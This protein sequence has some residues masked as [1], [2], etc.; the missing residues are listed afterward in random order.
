MLTP[1]GCTVRRQRFWAQLPDPRPDAVL[2]VDPL[3]LNY[4]ANFWASPF[5]FRSQGAAA[6][7]LLTADGKARL[8][9]DN[10]LEPYAALAHVDERIVPTWYDGRHAPGGRG[11]LLWE[12]VGELVRSCVP[13]VGSLG[14]DSPL[15][16]VAGTWVRT[17][18]DVE[19]VL[20]RLRQCKEPDELELLRRSAR[21][22]GVGLRRAREEARPGL[23]ELDLFHVVQAAVQH[24]LG[25]PV[26][27]YGDFVS[28]PR[29]AAG[30]G[31]PSSRRLEVGDLVLFDF[32]PVIHGYRA[33][34]CT[35]FV[36]GGDFD[37][38]QARCAQACRAALA[39]GAALLRPGQS[40]QS[41]Y[42]AVRQVFQEH[43]L[44]DRFPHHAGHGIGLSHPE[45]PFLTELSN[46]T[47]APG[48]VVTLEPGVYFPD[49]WGMRFE[50]D[51]LI[52][53]RG[54]VPLTDHEPG[55]AEA[56]GGACG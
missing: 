37:A 21:A 20:R 2:V 33:D 52:T 17:Q 44:A 38:E 6:A 5:T 42:A 28:G 24:E 23:S 32:S 31:G 18:V 46:E 13:A 8:V 16:G 26:P 30:G 12:T 56:L 51:F 22:S 29:T 39:A 41:V 15:G 3:H 53:D 55:L 35:T 40:A 19:P 34:V 1:A 9:A 25:E 7:L 43:G 49:R 45:A 47:L 48:M 50:H 10:L 14:I 54:C 27:I 4:L 36:V 11:T